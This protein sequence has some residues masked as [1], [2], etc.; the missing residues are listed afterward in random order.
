MKISLSLLV[1]KYLDRKNYVVC[2][3]KSDFGRSE[4]D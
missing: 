1:A 2:K 4:E 3:A